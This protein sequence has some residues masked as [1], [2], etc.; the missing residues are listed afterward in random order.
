MAF[1][2]VGIEVVDYVSKKTNQRV[3][4]KK[5]HYLSD[6]DSKKGTGQKAENDYVSGEIAEM[7]SVGDDIEIYYNRFGNVAQIEI[8]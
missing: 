8:I 6:I 5:I 7:V 4:G 2:V 3:V 1:R